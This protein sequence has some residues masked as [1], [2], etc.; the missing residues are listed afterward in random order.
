MIAAS[1]DDIENVS[2]VRWVPREGN[3]NPYVRIK[4]DEAGR[5]ANVGTTIDGVLNLGA[6]CI[7]RRSKIIN[8]LNSALIECLGLSETVYFRRF[9]KSKLGHFLSNYQFNKTSRETCGS[10]RKCS[11]KHFSSFSGFP[12]VL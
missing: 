9:L 12:S 7:V 6:G 5:F 10:V 3:E 1:I 11:T 8:V 2:C 4:E